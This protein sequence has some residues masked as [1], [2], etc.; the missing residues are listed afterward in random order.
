MYRHS[1]DSQLIS[2][3]NSLKLGGNETNEII[4]LAK[5]GHYQVACQRHFDTVHP[6]WKS[7][8]IKTAEDAANHP[9]QWFNASVEFHKSL[10]STK[11]STKPNT[12][13]SDEMVILE[14]NE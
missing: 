3:L 12:T 9:N 1:S 6:N 5:N 10:A 2:Q 7:M 14:P 8:N 11:L 4:K 13:S